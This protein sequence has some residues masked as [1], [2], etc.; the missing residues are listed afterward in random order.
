MHLIVKRDN[1]GSLRWALDRHHDPG[2]GLIN[3]TWGQVTTNR[4]KDGQ[5]PKDKQGCCRS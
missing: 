4:L 1:P 5:V 2:Q 3:Q